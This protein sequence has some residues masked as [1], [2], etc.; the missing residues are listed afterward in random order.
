MCNSSFGVGW[1]ACG[2]TMQNN[3]SLQMHRKK[4]SN[5]HR[6]NEKRKTRACAILLA[7]TGWSGSI[8]GCIDIDIDIDIYFRYIN[9]LCFG[10]FSSPTYF[11]Y[12]SFLSPT[13]SQSPRATLALRNLPG[14]PAAEMWQELASVRCFMLLL[15]RVSKKCPCSWLHHKQ[16]Q[17]NIIQLNI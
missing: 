8:L 10:A 4:D 13:G 14:W 12:R 2:C 1:R 3:Q 9:T 17:Y 16:L 5:R 15:P 7:I 11:S 6:R